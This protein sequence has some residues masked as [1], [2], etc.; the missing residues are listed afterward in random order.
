MCTLLISLSILALILSF[1]VK[2]ILSLLKLGPKTRLFCLF[3]TF[4]SY[5]CVLAALLALSWVILGTYN[6]KF[7]HYDF[8]FGFSVW[9]A[10]PN[11]V[12]D[13]KNNGTA[14]LVNL[15]YLSRAYNSLTWVF[16]CFL[17]ALT[18]WLMMATCYYQMLVSA[19][20]RRRR[21]LPGLMLLLR[22]V[23]ICRLPTTKL[24]YNKETCTESA[25]GYSL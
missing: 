19:P 15:E 2:S 20:A 9:Q 7:P 21:K 8:A 4:G 16:G 24:K 25:E 11:V 6:I 5:I 13:Y 14:S 23:R 1:C 17:G 18:V 22:T 12:I 3:L 10:P